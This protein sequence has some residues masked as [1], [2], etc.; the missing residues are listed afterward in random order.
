MAGSAV[1]TA[2]PVAILARHSEGEISGS[3]VDRVNGIDWID[4]V[5]GIDWIDWV[6]RVNGNWVCVRPGCR[7]YI[8]RRL[9][10]T[11]CVF[12]IPLG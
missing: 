2:E 10:P 11:V 1:F 9:A 7:Q 12:R 3:R 8:L 5:N 4:W 6:Y